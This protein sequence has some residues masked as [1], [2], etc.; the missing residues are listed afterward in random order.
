VEE[1]LRLR[2]ALMGEDYARLLESA[3]ALRRSDDP[4]RRL[5]AAAAL[6]DDVSGTAGG[7]TSVQT[8]PR[9]HPGALGR[10]SLT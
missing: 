6:R 2:A 4:V 9:L 8:R 7:A 5:R 10:R 1:A 3:V